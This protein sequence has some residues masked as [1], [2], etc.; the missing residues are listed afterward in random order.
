MVQHWSKAEDVAKTMQYLEQA[1]EQARQSG[2]YQAALRYF[3]QSL[4]LSAQSAVLSADYEA[5][6]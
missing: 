5:R 3:D 4:A 1:G 2:D 6:D